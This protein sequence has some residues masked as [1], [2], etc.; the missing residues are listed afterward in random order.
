VATIRALQAGERNNPLHRDGSPAKR[1]GRHLSGKQDLCSPLGRTYMGKTPRGCPGGCRRAWVGFEIT[2]EKLDRSLASLEAD[3]ERPVQSHGLLDSRAS[4]S[5]P[6]GDGIYGWPTGPS[7]A[8]GG[9]WQ[10]RD[11]RGLGRDRTPHVGY[12]FFPKYEFHLR[13]L[14]TERFASAARSGI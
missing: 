12:G 13:I 5:R 14:S 4:S 11:L 1:G 3:D 9:P 7:H 6:R 8:S 10:R 2:Y